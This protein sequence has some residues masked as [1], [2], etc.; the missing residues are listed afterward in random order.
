QE[1]SYE[2]TEEETEEAVQEEPKPKYTSPKVIVQPKPYNWYAA[3]EN[4]EMEV[5]RVSIRTVNIT[6]KDKISPD[7]DVYLKDVVLRIKN[8][9][10]YF[11]HMKLSFRLYDGKD[12]IIS[13]ILE[14]DPSDDIKMDGCKIALREGEEMNI[15]LRIDEKMPRI[16]ENKTMYI[17]LEEKTEIKSY[18]SLEIRKSFDLLNLSGAVYS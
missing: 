10:Y 13:E 16:Y 3:N 8:N 15:T 1:A 12:S 6:P 7:K 18:N 2:E 5:T 14:C 4:M 9:R 11:L 17:I